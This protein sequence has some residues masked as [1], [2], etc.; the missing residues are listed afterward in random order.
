MA[1]YR[2]S[3]VRQLALL[4]AVLFAV[5]GLVG[6]GLV[7]IT[8]SLTLLAIGAAGIVV[9]LAYTAPPLKLVYRGLGEIAVFCGFGPIM[10]LGSYVVQT[11]NLA[12]EPIV[13]S[14]PV[15]ILVALILYVNEIRIGPAMQRP[16]SERCRCAWRR[17]PS[18]A[19]T[20]ARHAWPSP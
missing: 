12:W 4:S 1:V 15:G 20:S 8:G 18:S 13:A 19:A 17:R 9:G 11:G 2:P 10:L 7:W 5:A 3:T 6:L 14:I 16:A